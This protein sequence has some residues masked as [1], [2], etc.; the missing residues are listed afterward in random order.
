VIGP[1]QIEVFYAFLAFP[2]SLTSSFFFFFFWGI[3]FFEGCRFP[4]EAGTT[5][6]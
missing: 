6:G 5:G 1:G 3:S 2:P 4:L